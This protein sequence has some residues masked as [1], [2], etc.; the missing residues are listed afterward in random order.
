MQ[1]HAV[2][3]VVTQQWIG[4]PQ[5]SQLGFYVPTA[6]QT[7]T[8]LIFYREPTLHSNYGQVYRVQCQIGEQE[9][10]FNAKNIESPSL[11]YR[12]V[13]SNAWEAYLFDMIP[14]P[15]CGGFALRS[16]LDGQFVTID[17][18]LLKMIPRLD[19]TCVFKLFEF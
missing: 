12:G 2:Q 5:V 17:E 3:H 7:V 13:S 1:R 16:V 9:F 11:I 4:T 8:P 18:G 14:I 10:F 19:E 15:R 6:S